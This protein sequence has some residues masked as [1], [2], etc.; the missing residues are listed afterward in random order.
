[1]R[2]LLHVANKDGMDEW[3]AFVVPRVSGLES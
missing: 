3:I 2:T 1:M